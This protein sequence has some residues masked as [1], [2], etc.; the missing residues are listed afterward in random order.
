MAISKEEAFEKGYLKHKK[1]K[2]MPVLRG[3]QMVKDSNH[4]NFFQY[5]GA[6]NWFQL[7]KDDRGQLAN[8]FES[9]EEKEFFE[10]EL[11]TNL[12][13][14]AET[15]KNFWKKTFLK[16][17]KDYNLMHSGYEFDLSDPMDV[18]RYKIA[19]KLSEV[20][21]SLD[22]QYSKPGYRF[23][24]VDEAEEEEKAAA[25]TQDVTDAYI[26]FGEIRNSTPKMKDFLGMYFN[27]KN[28]FKFVPAD[29]EKQWLQKE[30][31]SIIETDLR[32]FLK[33]KNDEDAPT[34]LLILQAIRA[35][36]INKEGRNKYNLLGEG[37]HYTYQEL[38]SYLK[39]AA[40]TKADV[41]L[42]LVAQIKV[43]K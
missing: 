40:E 19:T 5:D 28:E 15:S 41:Y 22:K 35:G 32:T 14:H 20:A 36:A 23:A 17:T 43:T 16:V 39:S 2:L 27:E 38:V 1:I 4:V 33:I 30:I 11:D 13:I 3:G 10:K 7:P 31:Q 8:P 42:K 26:Y 37:V 25:V 34:K 12:S 9:D 24:L 29:A 21:P 6:A 18:L